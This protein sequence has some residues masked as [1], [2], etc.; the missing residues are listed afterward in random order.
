MFFRY[1]DVNF[2]VNNLDFWKYRYKTHFSRKTSFMLEKKVLRPS[3]TIRSKFT[4]F[5]NFLSSP[6]NNADIP[7]L[8]QPSVVITDPGNDT[9]PFISYFL[10]LL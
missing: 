6:L 1:N 5:L 10:K 4:V 3:K 9:N 2:Y 8:P 7:T